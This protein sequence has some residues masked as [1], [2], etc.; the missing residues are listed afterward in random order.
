MWNA[1]TIYF[2]DEDKNIIEFIARK[3]SQFNST[4]D[5]SM[6]S[7]LGI[8]GIG[9]ATE[10]IDYTYNELT[11]KVGLSVYSASFEEFS[12]IAD[13]TGLVICVDNNK[14]KWFPAMDNAHP[15]EFEVKVLEQKNIILQSTQRKAKCFIELIAFSITP[16]PE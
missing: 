5:F 10:S 1:K 16:R 6:K 13:E 15:S 3:N 12:T 7:L 4:E 11:S 8:S 9:C 2:Y 14:M